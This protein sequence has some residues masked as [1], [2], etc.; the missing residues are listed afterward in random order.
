MYFSWPGSRC[1]TISPMA[2]HGGPCSRCTR[3]ASRCRVVQPSHNVGASGS[4]LR[5][6]SANACRSAST[7]MWHLFGRVPAAV[8]GP[9]SVCCESADG[10]VNP[11]MMKTRPH[12][13]PNTVK[14]GRDGG[15]AGLL[16]GL[17]PP[18]V[19]GAFD[20]PLGHL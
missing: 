15:V 12:T 1:P 6:T 7:G 5:N 16:L 13:N 18:G 2:A 3:W 10:Q 19:V 9:P 17:W 14:L 4:V 11:C 8:A 20:V